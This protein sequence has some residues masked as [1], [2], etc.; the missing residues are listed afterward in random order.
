MSSGDGFL[1]PVCHG[2]MGVID[3]DPRRDEI[4]RRRRCR[5]R[6]C[7]GRLTTSERAIEF[8][9]PDTVAVPRAWLRRLRMLVGKIHLDTES[10]CASPEDCAIPVID[11]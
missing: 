5:D 1:C 3:T 10:P 9:A 4:R 7:S 8:A 2:P 11:G 6:G